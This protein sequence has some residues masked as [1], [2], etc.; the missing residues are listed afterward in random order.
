MKHETFA[1]YPPAGMDLAQRALLT[2]WDCLAMYRDDLV[3]V[4]GLAVSLLTRPAPNGQPGPVTLDVDFGI[5]VGA[6]EGMYGSIRDTLSAHGF[7]WKGGRFIREIEGMKLY[8]DLLTDDGKSARGTV[9]VDDGLAVAMIPGIERA[10]RCVRVVEVT[11]RTLLNVQQTQHIRVA[12][13]GPLLVLKLNAYGGPT[14]RK[15]PKDAHDIIY[16]LSEYLD[17]PAKAVAAFHQEKSQNRAMTGALDTLRA[18]F[19]SVEGEGAIA[20]A[21]FRLSNQHESPELADESLRI[22]QLCVTLAEA[23]LA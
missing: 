23:L 10:M 6:S 12:D 22:R 20:C 19:A 9:T 14:G 15:A 7:R 18:G 17:G 2:V 5:N 4:G 21:A 13:V 16:L 1:K 8:V 3:L 11:G